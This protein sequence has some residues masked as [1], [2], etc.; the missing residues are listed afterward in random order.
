M[1]DVQK[2]FEKWWKL[3]AH[4]GATESDLK[5]AELDFKQ[6][7]KA[8]AEAERERVLKEIEE[9]ADRQTGYDVADDA[10]ESVMEVVKK[11]RCEQ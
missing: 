6:G 2:A 11:L 1:S 4:D 9:V 5:V 10:L 7:Y 8:G 3:A